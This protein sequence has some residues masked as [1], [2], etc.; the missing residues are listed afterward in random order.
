MQHAFS[1]RGAVQHIP[2]NRVPMRNEDSKLGRNLCLFVIVAVYFGIIYF[3]LNYYIPDKTGPFH[4]RYK[5]I[6]AISVTFATCLVVCMVVLYLRRDRIRPGILRFWTRIRGPQRRE[7][8]P[9]D[10]EMQEC[11]IPETVRSF[12]NFYSRS[13]PQVV[14]NE[15]EIHPEPPHDEPQVDLVMEQ[16]GDELRPE[17]PH[18][19]PRVDLIMELPGDL[20]QRQPE[21]EQ[22][23]TAEQQS[24]NPILSPTQF[25]S[26]GQLNGRRYFSRYGNVPMQF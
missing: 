23:P 4:I 17:S 8:R 14:P 24:P 9:E 3:S 15:E 11:L 25:S 10:I 6:V 7:Q 26:M 12:L 22:P 20:Q 5:I 16:P 2:H 21:L 18:H 13:I 19:E 1:N